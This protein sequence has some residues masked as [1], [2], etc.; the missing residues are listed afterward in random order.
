MIGVL[1]CAFV[2]FLSEYITIVNGLKMFILSTVYYN[3]LYVHW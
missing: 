3:A 1:K 2:S